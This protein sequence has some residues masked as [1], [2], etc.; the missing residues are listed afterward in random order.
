[1]LCRRA[2]CVRFFI[3]NTVNLVFVIR[4]IVGSHIPYYI[5]INPEI[6][7]RYFISKIV[8]LFPWYRWVLIY[9]K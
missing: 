6:F 8:H 9:H 1:M 5:I 3:N 2:L 7:M 4:Q